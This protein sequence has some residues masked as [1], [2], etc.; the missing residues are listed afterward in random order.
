[1]HREETSAA[2]VAMSPHASDLTC[3]TRELVHSRL[4]GEGSTYTRGEVAPQ[5]LN[6][7]RRLWRRNCKELHGYRRLPGKKQDRGGLEL[8]L[9]GQSHHL[10]LSPTNASF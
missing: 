7:D 4:M 1:M 9:A 3:M 8:E 10:T 6:N 2:R 5:E